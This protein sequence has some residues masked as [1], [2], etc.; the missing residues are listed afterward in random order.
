MQVVR[1]CGGAPPALSSAVFETGSREDADADEPLCIEPGVR[2]TMPESCEQL[3]RE[4]RRSLLSSASISVACAEELL[5][6]LMRY[7]M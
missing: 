1:L 7:V 2:S 6:S 4:P 3:V 5:V